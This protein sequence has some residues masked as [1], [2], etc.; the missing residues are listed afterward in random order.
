MAYYTSNYLD[1][2][3]ESGFGIFWGL[4]RKVYLVYYDFYILFR[5][6]SASERELSRQSITPFISR[7]VRVIKHE[8]I[9]I[10]TECVLQHG[11]HLLS[12]WQDILNLIVANLREPLSFSGEFDL[13][14]LQLWYLWFNEFLHLSCCFLNLYSLGK[15]LFV[16]Y[17]DSHVETCC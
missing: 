8:K 7:P 15:N 17:K 16:E 1:E 12:L 11:F 5:R 14:I 4:W 2:L 10:H 9:F 3:D 6:L 13:Q